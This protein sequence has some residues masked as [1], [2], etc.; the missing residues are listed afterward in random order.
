VNK[1]L[2][3]NV[4]SS[5]INI[6]LLEDKKLIELNTEKSNIRFSVGDIY[7]GKIKKLMPGLNAAFVNIGYER[8]AF[9][10]YHDLGPQ[11]KSLHNYLN[12]AIKHKGKLPSMQKFK[13]YGD[14]NKNGKI[15]K[16]LSV[17]QPVVTQITKEP[18]STKGP[19]L[20]SEISIAG[21]N[22]VIMP[23]N[24]KVSVSQKISSQEEKN[25]LKTL[26]QS[27]KPNNYGVI[28]RTVAEGKKVKDLD[29]EL[30]HLVNRWENS[31]DD[32]KGL[33]PP[34]M[35]MSELKRTSAILRDMLNVTFN[36]IYVNDERIYNEIT[37]YISTIA[38]EK[39]KIVKL[40]KSSTPIFENFGVEKQIKSSFGKTV[41]FKNG[42]YIIIEHT[43][44][45]HVIDVN[46][47]NR[48]KTAA[49]QETNALEVNVAA[50]NEIARQLRLRDMGGIIVIDFIDMQSSKN[51]Q[52]VNEKMKEFMSSD[53]AKHTILPLSKFGLMQITRQRVRP[54]MH[55]STT[56]ICPACNGTGE[57]SPSILFIDNI[58]NRISYIL[59]YNNH[60][61]LTLRVHPYIAAYL[62]KGIWPIRLKWR[63]QFKCKF[64]II[65]VSSYNFLEYHIF[66]EFGEEVS[67]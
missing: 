17:G 60:K 5:D 20:T 12:A 55:I 45:L 49:D 33:K 21:R 63:F 50:A 30:R 53:R 10:H 8:D 61:K 4:T 31:F 43:E 48:A 65:A 25:R 24:D 39:E 59:Q 14:I 66:D 26:L 3:I 64:K 58:K 11:F 40:Y 51:K 9:L 28:I 46:S 32:L 37:D 62:N 15:T 1:E 19:R 34:H 44:A 54:E 41:S 2:I 35:L 56:E 57:I 7:L 16:V 13:R 36:N 23:F 18:I 42:A 27:I 67:V 29:N 47:G 6:A 22:L 38:P 52:I